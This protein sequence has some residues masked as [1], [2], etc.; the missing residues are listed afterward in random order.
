MRL[1]WTLAVDNTCGD[2]FRD[3]LEA[4]DDGNTVGGDGCSAACALEAGYLCSGGSSSGGPDAC[5]PLYTADQ[6]EAVYATSQVR[7]G[8]A[9]CVIRPSSS[10]Q[11]QLNQVDASP[12]V[13][14]ISVL[15]CPDAACL[16]PLSILKMTSFDSISAVPPAVRTRRPG[17]YVTVQLWSAA[18]IDSGEGFMAPGY[19]RLR[20]SVAV[21]NTCG[22]GFRDPLEACDDGN[23]AGGDGCS[24]GCAVEAGY[25][26]LGATPLDGPDFCTRLL[27]D[28][29]GA[30]NFG[31]YFGDAL[32]R[33]WAIALPTRGVLRL[34]LRLALVDSGPSVVQ[35]ATCFWLSGDNRSALGVRTS[36]MRGNCPLA[37]LTT[38]EANRDGYAQFVGGASASV[39]GAAVIDMSLL[40]VP[41]LQP[42]MSSRPPVYVP[43]QLQWATALGKAACGDGLRDPLEGCDDGNRQGG[44]GCS[45]SCAV[46]AGYRCFG[47]GPDVCVPACADPRT[48]ASAGVIA[49]DMARPCVADPKDPYSS[50]EYMQWIIRPQQAGRVQLRLLAYS[51]PDQQAQVT[52]AECRTATVDPSCDWCHDAGT[53]FEREAGLLAGSSLLRPEKVGWV[54]RSGDPGRYFAV[55]IRNGWDVGLVRGEFR[56]AWSLAAGTV[57]GDGLRDAPEACDDGN[58][59]DGDGCSAACAVEAGYLC[60]GGSARSG[61]DACLVPRTEPSG[62]VQYYFAGAAAQAQTAQWAIAPPAAAG[63]V[64]VTLTALNLVGALVVFECL[65]PACGAQR[66]VPDPLTLNYNGLH[67]G[68]T[69]RAGAA[70]RP[71]RLVM[72]VSERHA[73]V[74]NATRPGA[75]AGL[76]QASWVAGGGAAAPAACGNSFREEGEDCDDGNAAGGDGC[77]AACQVRRGCH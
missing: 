53:L 71:V 73:A 52:V 65:D 59:A 54:L 55:T 3:P 57:C 18:N 10:G 66:Q 47:G 31:R 22:D 38:P 28:P 15:E 75:A 5:P 20:W 48:S 58:A 70:G 26:C 61:P 34:R 14:S 63:A 11:L 4:C 19:V 42:W 50:L 7:G 77:S 9:S 12:G 69:L 39:S 62:A 32:Q 27:S 56:L 45:G 60:A 16:Q 21:N 74:L 29:S 24:A 30:V 41:D 2:G 72:S 25:S 68:R 33:S 40:R 43:M 8:S 6:G 46:E 76:F 44:D 1:A 36:M 51:L 35:A 13:G 37:M 23:A 17:T 64:Q 49:Y 67:A